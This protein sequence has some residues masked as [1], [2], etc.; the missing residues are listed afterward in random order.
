MSKKQKKPKRSKGKPI[1]KKIGAKERS[2][3]RKILKKYEIKFSLT[4]ENIAKI[5]DRE[6]PAA[7]WE[8]YLRYCDYTR[9]KKHKKYLTAKEWRALDRTLP[10]GLRLVCSVTRSFSMAELPSTWLTNRPKR[11]LKTWMP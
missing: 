11:S 9:K 3:F 8:Y 1:R 5:P 6:L 2:Q 7:M 4:P 10:R